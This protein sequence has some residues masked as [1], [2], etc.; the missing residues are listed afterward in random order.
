MKHLALCHLELESG[1]VVNAM[2]CPFCA[3]VELSVVRHTLI[4]NNDGTTGIEE[5]TEG[6]SVDCDTCGA[7]GPINE[8]ES[9]SITDWNTRYF[10]Q[11]DAAAPWQYEG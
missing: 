9:K 10:Y 11:D 6:W 4:T 8:E 2:P 3:A 1:E 5:V 7:A